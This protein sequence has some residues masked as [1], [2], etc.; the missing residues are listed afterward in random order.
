MILIVTFC[1]H[2]HET[3]Q[4]HNEE[5]VHNVTWKTIKF[6]SKIQVTDNNSRQLNNELLYLQEAQGNLKNDTHTLEEKIMRS[7][8]LNK[9]EIPNRLQSWSQV[10]ASLHI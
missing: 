7:N 8:R 9:D 5:A 1:Y 10:F 2:L 3:I 6:V 4:S